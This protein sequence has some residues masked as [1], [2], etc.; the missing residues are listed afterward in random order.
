MPKTY[1]WVWYF[2]SGLI[3]FGSENC[4]LISKHTGSL[5][6]KV[7]ASIT[8]AK[9][10]MI[11]VEANGVIYCIDYT[12]IP[13]TNH[14]TPHIVAI[15]QDGTIRFKRSIPAMSPNVNDA[16]LQVLPGG[17]IYIAYNSVGTDMFASPRYFEAEFMPSG[18]IISC[19]N[20]SQLN[21]PTTP[22]P[23]KPS[24]SYTKVLPT[25]AIRYW[26]ITFQSNILSDLT[27][28][29]YTDSAG[30]TYYNN[31]YY[32]DSAGQKY[33]IYEAYQGGPYS[34]DKS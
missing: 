2:I 22:N 29:L 30:N 33:L 9:Y 4:I 15:N 25:T 27:L 19:Q 1:S 20:I 14:Y 8:G 21:K 17:N 7:D 23:F 11:P 34:S 13:E 32:V 26:S 31:G 5:A 18:T 12:A 3:V 10:A 28:P 16:Y 24:Y 6:W